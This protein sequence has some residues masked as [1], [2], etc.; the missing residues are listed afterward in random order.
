MK[1]VTERP[2]R[3]VLWK[4]L[5]HIFSVNLVKWRENNETQKNSFTLESSF[6]LPPFCIATYFYFLVN[7]RFVHFIQPVNENKE[8]NKR[9]QHVFMEKCTHLIC[10]VKSSKRKKKSWAKRFRTFVFS[11]NFCNFDWTSSWLWRPFFKI[12]LWSLGLYI[13]MYGRKDNWVEIHYKINSKIK[14]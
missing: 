7:A 1:I 6:S 8:T 10:T 2:K 13:E 9:I 12:Y 4:R 5:Q 3:F 14:Q 11:F